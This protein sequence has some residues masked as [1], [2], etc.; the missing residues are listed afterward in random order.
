MQQLLLGSIDFN[1]PEPS[2]VGF[3]L[4]RDGG[5]T[6]KL[7]DCMPVIH[8]GGLVYWPGDEPSVGYDR[9][10]AGYIAGGYADSEGQGYGFVAV[11]KSTDGTHWSKPIIALRQLRRL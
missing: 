4:S 11:Q 3:H 5:S 8:T 1:C 10:G 9:H 7:V 6:W 2:D